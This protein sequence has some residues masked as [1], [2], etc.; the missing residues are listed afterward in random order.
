MRYS[1]LFI[2]VLALPAAGSAQGRWTRQVRDAVTN[3]GATF[4]SRG[5]TLTHEIHDGSLAKTA[6]EDFWVELDAGVQYAL[7]GVCDED[8]EDIDLG[9]FDAD[10]EQVDS[11]YELDEVPIVSVTPSVTGRYRVHAYMASCDVEPCFYGV[12]VFGRGTAASEQNNWEQQV[13][14]QT[15]E[16]VQ[17]MEERG[18]HETHEVRTGKLR[19]DRSEDFAVR[20]RAGMTYSLAGFCDGDCSDLDLAIYSGD[21]QLDSDYELDDYPVVAVRVAR[22]GMFRVHVS[23]A[24]CSTEPCYYGVALVGR[25]LGGEGGRTLAALDR[26]RPLSR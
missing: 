15:D 5:Y 23:M 12:G 3:A 21:E 14:R 19:E 6:S 8:C 1:L 13:F 9:L 11:D 16:F 25:A 2:A 24:T 18:Y 4:A 10:G 7:V 20:L 22:T 17:R 26:G